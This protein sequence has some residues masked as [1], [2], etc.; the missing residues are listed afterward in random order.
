M[1]IKLQ[2]RALS[3]LFAPTIAVLA[4]TEMLDITI[5]DKGALSGKIVLT[6]NDKTYAADE[7]HIT[8]PHDALKSVNTA[9]LTERDEN[10]GEVLRT[11][12]CDN[13]YLHTLSPTAAEQEHL[14]TERAF[15]KAC[16]EEQANRLSELFEA[17]E[18]LSALLD[19]TI[20]RV[21]ALE[22]GKFTILKFK[23]EQTK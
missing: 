12:V 23:G 20:E 22:N 9:T 7:K 14:L 19:K 5:V 10:T 13:L 1:K 15:Y 3:A 21:A 2:T 11:F 17:Y 6:F 18:G 4:D 16:I 8:I